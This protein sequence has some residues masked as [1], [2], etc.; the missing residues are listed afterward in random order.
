MFGYININKPELKMKEYYEYQAFYCGL[1]N[2]LKKKY[3]PLGQMTLTYD[4]TFL[5]I[6]LS[7]LYE[8]KTHQENHRCLAHPTTKHAILEN[9]ITSYAADM[10]IALTYY[11]MLDDWQDD[12]SLQGGAFAALLKGKFKTVAKTYPRQCEVIRTCLEALKE[13]ET[14]KEANLD[15]VSRPFGELMAEIFVYKEDYFS[16]TL[17]NLGFYLGKFI[18]LLDAYDDAKEDKQNGNYNP[19]LFMEGED[20]EVVCEQILT[21]MMAECTKEFEKLPLIRD[22]QILR[23][24]LYAG[25][26]TKY[27]KMKEKQAISDDSKKNEMK[28]IEIEK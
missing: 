3:G 14:R 4:M 13:C 25:V 11:K 23:N 7:S 17:R 28:Q 22:A 24:I 9:E 18:Y 1:C 15:V 26:W 5:V 19:L 16:N 20:Y 12:R 8:S 10:N 27:D 2:T 6:L 21:M